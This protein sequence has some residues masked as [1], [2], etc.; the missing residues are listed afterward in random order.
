M[1]TLKPCEMCGEDIEAD[2]AICPHCGENFVGVWRDGLNV[3]MRKDAELPPRCIKTNEPVQTWLPR[4]LVWHPSWVY[5]LILLG[6][7]IYV[8]AAVVIQKQAK[9]K[10]GLTAAVASKRRWA[11]LTAWLLVLVGLGVFIGG[12]AILKEDLTV[13][14]VILGLVMLLGGIIYGMVKG[15]MVTPVKVTKEYAI[16]KGACQEY[17][18]ELPEWDHRTI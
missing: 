14:T 5:V 15:R 3:V 16:F 2:V 6:L 18:D 17:L 13:I 8:I 12:F 7:L 11:I 1:T 10:I 9:I 4:T